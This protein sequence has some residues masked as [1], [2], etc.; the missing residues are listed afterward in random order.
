MEH[1]VLSQNA[2][3]QNAQAQRTRST[4]QCLYIRKKDHMKIEQK[5]TMNVKTRLSLEMKLKQYV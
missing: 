3:G 4:M 2:F 1:G 5:W